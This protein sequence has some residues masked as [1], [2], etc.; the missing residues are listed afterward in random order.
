MSHQFLYAMPIAFI[1]AGLPAHAAITQPVG[2]FDIGSRPEVRWECT[3][4]HTTANL[5]L[6]DAGGAVV[7][8]ETVKKIRS[9]GTPCI[10]RGAELGK[11][12]DPPLPKAPPPKP[13]EIAI[14]PPKYGGL[15]PGQY[16]LKVTLKGAAVPDELLT[17]QFTI[18]HNIY[19]NF[20]FDSD[21]WAALN[22]QWSSLLGQYST[23]GDT[24]GQRFISTYDKPVFRNA[25]RNQF[26]DD[27]HF[28]AT[29]IPSCFSSK[30]FA[31]I[32]TYLYATGGGVGGTS[33][34]GTEIVVDGSNMLFVRS[35][36][37]TVKSWKVVKTVLHGLDVSKHITGK[38]SFTL[39]V[40]QNPL[41]GRMVVEL[42][43]VRVWCGFSPQPQGVAGQTGLVY[44][45]HET[46]DSVGIDEF[47][48]QPSKYQG[49][50]LPC[51]DIL[52]Y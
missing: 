34:A 26:S 41:L 3:Q 25:K 29:V 13:N 42:D 16:S 33:Y 46:F 52:P 50:S 30:C 6:I 2:E 14:N 28:V 51:R 22:G 45:G 18:Q 27:R 49:N 17:S 39:S 48:V 20:S 5:L 11:L 10:A 9:G 19:S 12:V 8:D 21:G 37:G 15:P 38:I 40:H 1:T 4:G 43:G 24:N 35:I 7:F 31:G 36:E 23:T 47:I 32:L 44:V